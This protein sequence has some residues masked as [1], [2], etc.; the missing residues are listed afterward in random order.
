M[1]YRTIGG[2]GVYEVICGGESVGVLWGSLRVHRGLQGSMGFT[3]LCGKQSVG[4]YRVSGGLSMETC[5]CS[6]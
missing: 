4:I 1:D 5:E 6:P 2:P 3:G